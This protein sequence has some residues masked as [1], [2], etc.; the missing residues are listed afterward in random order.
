MKTAAGN[1]EFEKAA[2]LRDELRALE[3]LEIKFL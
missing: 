2:S 1:L 3:S